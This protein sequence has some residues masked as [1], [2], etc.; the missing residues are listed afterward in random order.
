M[1]TGQ[2]TGDKSE[3]LQAEIDRIS[4]A[5]YTRPPR[6][7]ARAM[8]VGL[9]TNDGLNVYV[10]DDGTY[11]FTY[12]E[13][14]QLSFDQVGELDDVLYWYCVGIVASQASKQFGDRTRRFHYEFQVLS[15]FN[16]EWAKRRV[17]DLAASFRARRPEDLALLPDIGE[18][19]ATTDTKVFYSTPF[20]DTRDGKQKLFLLER[21]GTQ[22]MPVFRSVESMRQFYEQRNRAAYMVLEGDVNTLRATNRSIA[23][24]RRVGIVI[25]PLSDRPVEIAP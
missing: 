15:Q 19:V 13:R 5:L 16:P 10:A 23:Q 22:Y 2:P 3:Q 20:G 11:H 4:E 12:Y 1:S 18:P 7:D 9:L 25:E 6:K 14:G 21:E 8:P 17:R 24:L